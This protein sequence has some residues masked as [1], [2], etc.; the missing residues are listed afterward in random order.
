MEIDEAP[1][2][3]GKTMLKNIGKSE[4]SGGAKSDRFITSTMVSN[5]S[6]VRP[7]HPSTSTTSTSKTKPPSVTLPLYSYKDHT[8]PKPV[9]VFTRVEEEANDLV[10]SLKAG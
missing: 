2:S 1:S 7:S 8:D 6:S 4:A 10:T 5:P 9:M 3:A